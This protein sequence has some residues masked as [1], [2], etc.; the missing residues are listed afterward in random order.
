VI[1]QRRPFLYLVFFPLILSPPLFARE[2]IEIRIEGV[3]NPAVLEYIREGLQEA[4]ERQAEFLL[5]RLNTP[6]GLMET[7]RGIVQLLLDAPVPVV[8]WVYPSGAHAASAGMFIT[9]S[10]HI[11]VMSPGTN[12]GA[13]TPISS[14]G[15]DVEEEGGKDLKRKVLEDTQAFARSIAELRK[16]PQGWMEQAVSEAVSITSEEAL[17]L[18]VIDLVARDL[19]EL[20]EKLDGWRVVV[21]NEQKVLSTK[22]VILRPLPMRLSQRIFHW[23]GHPNIAYLLL[24][25]GMLGIYFELSQPGGYFGGVIGAISLLLA[26]ISLQILPFRIGG[27]LLILL[28]IILLILEVLYPTIGIFAVGGVIS[29]FIG[30]LILFETPGLDIRPHLG[31]I[32]TSTILLAGAVL[33]IGFL[34]VRTHRRKSITGVEGMIGL[35]GEV[36]IRIDPVGKVFCRGEIWDA[37]SATGEPIEPPQRVRVKGVDGLTLIVERI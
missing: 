36:R 17:R 7:T 30:S 11:A 32:I 25:L 23:L 20:L 33:L 16:R 34:V 29:F 27:L 8:V 26:F 35:E 22:G 19:D 21:R 3:I 5:I 14:Q 2:V 31:V 12:I 13:A 28:G 15:K 24:L 9:L 4:E 1:R 37:R 18:K 6:G 10:A